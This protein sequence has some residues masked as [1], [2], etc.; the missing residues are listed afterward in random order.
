MPT[1]RRLFLALGAVAL[2]I[3]AGGYVL[4]RMGDGRWT[5]GEGMYMSAI[6]AATVGF[7]E[8][9]GLDHVHGARSVTVGIILCGI[10]AFTFFQSSLTAV[11]VEDALGTLF[12]RRRMENVIANLKDHI[13]VAGCGST[14]RHVVEDLVATGSR[15]VVID[16]DQTHLERMSAELASGKMLFVV[17]DATADHTLVAAN[18]AHAAGVIA[19]LTHDRDNLYVTLSAR[20]LNAKARIVAKVVELEAVPKMLRAGANATVSPNTIGGRRMASEVIRPAVVEFLEQ[21]T[22]DPNHPLRFE[23]VEVPGG[24]SLIGETLMSAHLRQRANILVVA[25]REPGQRIRYNPD[26][27]H[28][29]TAGTVLIVMGESQDVERLRAMVEPKGR[30][31]G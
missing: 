17:G 21:M 14:G 31:T 15:F 4:F 24:S 5:L 10:G 13:V 28:R 16:R 27:E 22:R 7:S 20:T 12:R 26:A 25:L 19:C 6:S 23:D 1:I 18:V 11:L 29:I 9:P 30:A 2:V 8:L 3:L